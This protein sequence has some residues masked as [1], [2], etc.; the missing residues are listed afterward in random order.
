[1]N[2]STLPLTWRA[3]V[4]SMEPG[5]KYYF[6]ELM[7]LMRDYRNSQ[8]VRTMRTVIE[9]AGQ[10]IDCD[11]ITS[12]YGLTPKG[13]AIRETAIAAENIATT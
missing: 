2:E 7:T 3:L 5:K 12:K 13:E 8:D 1:M 9:A 4:R 6:G 10:N 11:R